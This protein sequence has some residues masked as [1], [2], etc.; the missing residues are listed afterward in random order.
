MRAAKSHR[1]APQ[2][3]GI[4]LDAGAFHLQQDRQQAAF[5]LFV[6][7]QAGVQRAGAGCSVSHSRRVTSASSAA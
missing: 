1:H 4:D 3:V 7:R 2:V 5:E 6:E